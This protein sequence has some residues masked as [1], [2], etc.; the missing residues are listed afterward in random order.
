M[1]HKKYILFQIKNNDKIINM[2]VDKPIYDHYQTLS[3]GRQKCV[4]DMMTLKLLQEN[5]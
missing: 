1:G 2:E 4:Q 5:Y 3:P